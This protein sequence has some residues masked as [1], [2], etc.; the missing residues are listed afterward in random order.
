[1]STYNLSYCREFLLLI[2]L[3]LHLLTLPNFPQRRQ[4]LHEF[5]KYYQKAQED[6]LSLQ[7]RIRLLKIAYEALK[8]AKRD[9]LT[10]SRIS[11]IVELSSQLEDSIFFQNAASEGL[12]LAHVLNNPSLIADAHWNYGSYY[13]TKKKF[14]SSYY[15]YDAAYK[16]FTAAKKNYYAGKM[17][18]NMAYI[19]SQTNDFTGAEILLFR[20]IKNFEKAEN[21]KQLY[22]CYNLLGTNA[23]DMEEYKKALEYYTQADQFI[24]KFNNSQYYQLELWNNMG[25]RLHKIGRY[26]HAI[27]YFDRALFYKETLNSHP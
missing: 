27:S 18:Y 13:L 4:T 10:Y 7:T 26:A 17:L 25:V 24:P 19:S 6:T 12:K 5:E 9:S 14:D 2:L 3:S 1:M 8:D 15:H 20:C 11:K 21:Y 16:L 22:L 23:D